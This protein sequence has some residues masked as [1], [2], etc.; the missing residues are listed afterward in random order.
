VA[1]RKGDKI[2]ITTKVVRTLP[3]FYPE[4]L[5]HL[6]SSLLYEGFIVVGNTCYITPNA[7][8]ILI[9]RC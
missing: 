7:L 4:V 3:L 5:L 9:D 1:D 2:D 6:A 8:V